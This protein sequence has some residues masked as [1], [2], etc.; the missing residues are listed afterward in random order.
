MTDRPACMIIT[1]IADAFATEIDRLADGG[2][3]YVACKNAEQ[4]RAE[5]AGQQ[6]LFGNP[7]LI[8]SVLP[9]MHEVRWVQSSWAGVTPLIELDQRNYLLTGVKDVFGP[10]MSEYV[11]GYLLAHELKIF[12]RAR[13]QKLRHWDKEF[14]GTLR[15]KRLGIMGC[16]SIGRH[17]AKTAQTFGL[18]VSGLSRSGSDLR[19]FDNIFSI[20]DISPFLDKLDYLVAALPQTPETNNLLNHSSLARLPAHAYFINV[21]RSNVVVDDDLIQALHDKTL[22][23]AVLDVFDEE[24]VAAD[25]ALWDTPNLTITAHIAAISHPLLIVPI[26]VE[27]YRRYIE[28][29]PLN[30]VINFATGY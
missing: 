14:S 26:F 17:I 6:I 25:S 9:H 2:I 11:F 22:A 12:R 21:G 7:D 10:Q 28:N 5:Y 8:S 24:P 23:G 27:N 4:A 20:R 16:G 29:L 19:E 1:S 15:G 13:Q 30:Y 3:P 18:K